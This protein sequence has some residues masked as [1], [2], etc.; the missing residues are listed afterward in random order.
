MTHAFSTAGYQRLLDL[1]LRLHAFAADI[2]AEYELD[3][4]TPDH[5]L[6]AA[7]YNYLSIAPMRN[8]LHV[9]YFGDAWETALEMMLACLTEQ[10]VADT[11]TSLAFSGPDQG[12]NGTR[13]WSFETLLSA[14]VTFPIL[15]SLSIR[16]TE[17]DHHNSS[18][19][20]HTGTIMEEGGD[21]ARLVAKMPYLTELTVPNAPDA[22]IFA[23]SLPHL[24]A[25][26]IGGSFDTQGFIENLASATNL[27]ALTS[28]DFT[29]STEL[30]MTWAKDRDDACVTSFEAYARLLASPVGEALKVFI[31]RNSRLDIDQLQ[32][33]RA[34]RPGLQ[35][36]VI[37]AARGGYVSHFAKHVFPWKHLVPGDPGVQ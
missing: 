33:L 4:G 11:I 10:A 16:P 1:Q 17:P 3:V 15:R 7:Q 20:V 36:M 12:A 23:Q 26:R 29:E 27:P 35:F 21:I 22:S 5:P 31:L 34:I 25:L 37:Q 8:G 24:R 28:L 18:L 9:E 2:V 32:S 6:W 14:E 19:I 13:E 30:Q